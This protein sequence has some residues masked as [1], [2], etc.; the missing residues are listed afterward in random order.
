MILDPDALSLAWKQSRGNPLLGF[1]PQQL[2]GWMTQWNK[3]QLRPFALYYRALEEGADLTI[4]AVAP[5]RRAGVASRPWVIQ[6]LDDSAEAKLHQEALS[7]FYDNVTI[8]DAV[9]Q[10][11][12]GGVKMLLRNMAQA[13]FLRYD[14]HE[15][16]WEPHGPDLTATLWHCPLE[17]LENRRGM[18]RFAGPFGLMGQ[19]ECRPG[20]WLIARSDL[21]L[22]QPLSLAA[23]FTSYTYKD[24]LNYNMG[25]SEPQPYATTTAGP[26][27]KEFEHAADTMAKWG[28]GM[29]ALF[30][31]GVTVDSL[32]LGTDGAAIYEPMVDKMDRAK[33]LL[34]MGS[35]LSTLSQ[36]NHAGASL[37]GNDKEILI[38]D[39][40][41]AVSE[42][43]N[44]GIDR[45]VIAA[46][47]GPGVKPRAKFALVAPVTKDVK[48]IV[49][50]QKH[51]REMGVPQSIGQVAEELDHELPGDGEELIVPA[52]VVQGPAKIGDGESVLPAATPAAN[53]AVDNPYGTPAA[54]S[55]RE[56]QLEDLQALRTHIAEALQTLQ[57]GGDLVMKWGIICDQIFAGDHL[58]NALAAQQMRSALIALKLSP[59]DASAILQEATTDKTP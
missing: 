19:E 12:E 31:A 30:G 52:V 22:A 39:D 59:E 34:I 55:L 23:V 28:P 38:L 20:E 5:K 15:I 26:G 32:S 16:V 9:D 48:G 40:L 43:A 3:G 46:V 2:T 14:A 24:W 1:T 42:A 53:E 54:L 7:Y 21:C 35:D 11:R 37:Q 36:A 4:S 56:P 45:H 49:E 13:M 41:E 33:I 18:M 50:K 6:T 17:M 44:I 51:L 57:G 8:K 27:T 47:F 29:R 25:Y 10:N 58:E